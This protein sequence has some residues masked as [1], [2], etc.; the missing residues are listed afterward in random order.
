MALGAGAE[1]HAVHGN[2]YARAEFV[3]VVCTPNYARRSNARKGGVGYEQQIISGYMARGLKKKRFVPIL[4][5]GTLNPGR[6]NAM[7]T[8]LSGIFAV[9]LRR[10]EGSKDEFENLIRAIFAEPRY[11]PPAL[12]HAPMFTRA[13]AKRKR[14]SKSTALRLPNSALDGYSLR[15][16][17]ASAELHPKTFHIPS[18]TR[19]AR[20]GKGD[21]VKLIFEY[22]DDLLQEL[23]GMAGERMW[24]EITGTKAPYLVG[25]LVSQ[26]LGQD[27]RGWPLTW[28]DQV[29]LLPEHVIDIES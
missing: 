14:R 17:V 29:L 9:D 28:G 12:G 24:V 25:K 19:R 21:L 4:R 6:N 15:S 13:S 8:H 7:P 26:P 10:A 18:A 5:S 23:D 20:L 2:Q 3:I 11:R 16:G 27:E 22:A 1:C